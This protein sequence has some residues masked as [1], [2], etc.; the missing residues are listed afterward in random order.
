MSQTKEAIKKQFY[1]L[2]DMRE[3]IIFE[4]DDAKDSF[5]GIALILSD[6]YFDPND[7][8]RKEIQDDF[9]NRIDCVTER[10]DEIREETKIKDR[11]DSQPMS[12]HRLQMADIRDTA[13]SLKNITEQNIV[14]RF[15][16]QITPNDYSSRQ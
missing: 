4:N 3:D 9:M 8:I 13:L 1:V 14:R 5:L 12:T 2:L 15:T 10:M 7:P 16:R 6:T 11:G